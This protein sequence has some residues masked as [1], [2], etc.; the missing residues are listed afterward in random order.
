[1]SNLEQKNWFPQTKFCAPH[2]GNDILIRQD[3]V[4]QLQHA[5]F[6]HSLTIISSPAGSGKTTLLATWQRQQEDSTQIAW[7]RF[8]KGDDDS[9]TFLSVLIASLRLVEP[10]FGSNLDTLLAN[11]SD[12]EKQ[13]NRLMGVIINHVISTIHNPFVLVLD[14]LHHITE[15]TIHQA[16]DYLLEHLPEAMSIVAATRYDPPLSLARMRAQGRLAELHLEALRFSVNES[17]SLLNKQ[18]RLNLTNSDL[19]MLQNRTEGWIAGLRLLALSLERMVTPEERSTFIQHLAQTDRYIFDF[20]AEEV[21]HDQAPN[22]QQFLLETSIL[23]ELTPKL[24]DAVTGCGNAIQLLDDIYRRNLFLTTVNGARKSF[25]QSYRYHDL[26][27]EFL[28]QRLK[29][30][31]PWADI[32]ALYHRAAKAAP[33]PAQAI[34]YYLA[35]ELWDDAANVIE[36]VGRDELTQSYV[37]IPAHW[38]ESLP[39][40]VY[41]GRPWLRLIVAM[42]EIH[43]GHMPKAFSELDELLSLFTEADDNLGLTYSLV[44]MIMAA[45]GIRDLEKADQYTDQLL[46][47]AVAPS[48]RVFGLGSKAWGAYFQQDWA[49]V[50]QFLQEAME[51]PLASGDYSAFQAMAHMQNIEVLFSDI[52]TGPME[53]YCQQVLSRYPNEGGF[54]EEGTHIMLGSIYVLQGKLTEAEKSIFRALELENQLGGAAWSG[55]GIDVVLLMIAMSQADYIKI[56]QIVQ[57][58]FEAMNQSSIYQQYRHYYLYTWGRALWAQKKRDQFRK[59]HQQMMPL[60]S[61]YEM[62][63]MTIA[64]AVIGSLSDR[65]EKRYDEAERKL[66]EVAPLQEQVRF[67]M[68]IGH[69][70]FELASLYLSL[71][72]PRKA[73]AQ[74]RPAL[75]EIDQRGMS[76]LILCEGPSM[77]PL[78]EFSL[79]HNLQ[80]D[81]IRPLLSFW[82]P[83]QPIQPLP[84]PQTGMSLTPREVEVLRLLRRGATNRSIAKTLAITE[85]TVKA[86]MTSILSKLGATTR[87]EAVARIQEFS[88]KL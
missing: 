84:I 43:R 59:V 50:G 62:P 14:D 42:I 19:S 77:I 87:T 83:N 61:D 23:T 21:L 33:T 24:C 48:L 3:L 67:S 29:L 70:R 78:L 79:T 57:T 25:E 20:L 36:S 52:G 60:S 8:D 49:K 31:R 6:V 85:R 22:M 53:N 63:E 56:E 65:H 76:G 55:L 64:R 46:A 32:Q 34:Y 16:L 82:S 75:A 39:T 2:V 5:I 26:F 10:N 88:L 69:V 4:Q 66:L 18:L 51:V 13:L 54:I 7:I 38:L 40:D 1:M 27:I 68:L 71:N 17:R 80:A 15:S 37:C 58:A 30:E 11:L 74:L 73:L 81:L 47:K 45:N 28:Q 86:H 35:A 72:Q 41:R 12:H 9:M 44:A